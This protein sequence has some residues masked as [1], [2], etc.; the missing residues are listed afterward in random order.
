MIYKSF[1]HPAFNKDLKKLPKSVF[2]HADKLTLKI[3]DAPYCSE[4]LSGDLNFIFRHK[5]RVDKVD[6][7]LAY[8]VDEIEKS[9]TF[10]M[11]KKRERFYEQL[12]NRVLD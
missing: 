12:R 4:K 5:F 7:R 3:A 10:L 1:F 11:V 8:I 2:S 6:Y 9:V